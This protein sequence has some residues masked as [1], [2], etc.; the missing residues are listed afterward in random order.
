MLNDEVFWN[1]VSSGDLKDLQERAKHILEIYGTSLP[2]NRFDVGNSMEFLLTDYLRSLGFSISEYPNAKRIDIAVEGYLN[3]SIKYSSIGNITLHN[4]NSC[5]NKDLH[6]TDLLLLTPSC[7]FLITHKNLKE[8]GINIDDYLVN[9]GDSL[10]LKR[11]L[12]TKLKNINF[13]YRIPCSLKVNKSKCLNKSCA[14]V[15]YQKAMQD[16]DEVKSSSK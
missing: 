1:S 6:M 9:K 16:Y 8:V 14:K 12:L 4:S 7:L 3:L 11:T 13:K 2:C 10:K 15:F 5:I